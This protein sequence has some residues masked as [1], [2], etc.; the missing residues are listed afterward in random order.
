MNKNIIIALAFISVEII[1]LISVST[2]NQY[3]FADSSGFYSVEVTNAD[4]CSAIASISYQVVVNP[5]PAVPVI[6]AVV[7]TLFAS[8]SGP[9]QWYLNGNTIAGATGSYYVVTANGNYSVMVTDSNGCE[10]ASL[11]YIFTTV[12]IGQISAGNFNVF[13]NPSNGVY[14]VQFA[15][16]VT[17]NS[18]MI[19]EVTGK[20]IRAGEF[21]GSNAKL[22]IGN[23]PAGIYF[24]TITNATSSEVIK[25]VKN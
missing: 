11:P 24:L 13:P 8:G 14:V 2:S 15:E 18:Y 9:F 12:G 5:L 20:R 16:K 19:H 17:G 1:V 4:G 21:N 10:S 25:L 6:T 22:D 23:V 3:T 7:D